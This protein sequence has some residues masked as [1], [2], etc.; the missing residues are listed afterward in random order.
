MTEL[1][2]VIRIT[3][4]AAYFFGRFQDALIGY[5]PLI[6][7]SHFSGFNFLIRGHPHI[8]SPPVL[9][10][11]TLLNKMPKFYSIK[12]MTRGGGFSK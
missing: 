4:E 7:F 11:M 3:V 2:L 6:K 8:T 12:L 1:T 10:M 9:K 5:P